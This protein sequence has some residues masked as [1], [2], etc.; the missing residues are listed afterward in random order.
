MP[1]LLVVVYTTERVDFVPPMFTIARLDSALDKPLESAAQEEQA[2]LTYYASGKV[3][4][5]DLVK[6]RTQN[7][8]QNGPAM[9]DS[10]SKITNAIKAFK[11]LYMMVLS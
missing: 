7:E 5:L 4:L 3:R 6:A 9:Y 11:K 1:D 10:S 8:T 2:G